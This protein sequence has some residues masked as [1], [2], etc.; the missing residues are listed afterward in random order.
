MWA[1]YA[2]YHHGFAI[3][4][5]EEHAFFKG[6]ELVPGLPRLCAVEYKDKRPVLSP[7]TQNTPQI[8]FRKSPDWSYEREWR[9]IRPLNESDEKIDKDPCPVHL[10]SVPAEAIVEIVTGAQMRQH[11]YQEL[12]RYCVSDDKLKHLTIHHIQLS[13]DTYTLETHPPIDGKANPQARTGKAMYAR[14]FDI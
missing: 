9:L 12:C 13:K 10:F 2:D 8:F 3:G 5:D 6:A 14:D 11:E 7:S 4:F 1:H